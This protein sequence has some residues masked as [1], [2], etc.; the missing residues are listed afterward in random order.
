M[1]DTSPV[2]LEMIARQA[3]VSRATVSRALRNYHW[4]SNATAKKVQEIAKKLGYQTDARMSELMV[5]LRKRKQVSS[6]PSLAV[7]YMLPS[8]LD[9]DSKQGRNSITEAVRSAE[10]KGYSLEIF[11]LFDP[12][13]TPRRLSQIW[14]NRNI[15]GVIVHPLNRPQSLEGFQ[16]HLFSWVAINYS[17]RAP[18]MNRVVIDYHQVTRLGITKALEQGS[19]RIGF[20]LP[21]GL[22]ERTIFHYRSTYLG[23]RDLVGPDKLAPILF[24][25]PAEKAPFAKWLKEHN[26]DTIIAP[27][28]ITTT[29]ISKRLLAA[30]P[31]QRRIKVINLS[32]DDPNGGQAG[33]YQ[34]A[35]A[36]GNEA[37]NHVIE[38]IHRAE[39]G[40]PRHPKTVMLP[41][42]WTGESAG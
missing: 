21:P 42:I 26:P 5:H 28:T 38:L 39:K 8:R 23:Y 14:W 7:L 37:V 25:N 41:G 24:A 29:E 16:W 10:E 20:V 11:N 19:R 40:L 34:D 6:R 30:S 35:E 2:T 22:D 13:M 27:G 4:T 15:S 1:S 3:G 31:A 36:L 9:F 12:Q 33:I 18:D 32:V 17:M